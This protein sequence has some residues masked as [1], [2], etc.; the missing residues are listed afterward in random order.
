MRSAHTARY[1]AAARE[2]RGP[3]RRESGTSR[4]SISPSSSQSGERRATKDSLSNTLL[5][6]DRAQ[7]QE[8][9]KTRCVSIGYAE[10]CGVQRREHVGEL[11]LAQR[12]QFRRATQ[13]ELQRFEH[14]AR[15]IDAFGQGGELARLQRR[16]QAHGIA[17]ARSL[18]EDDHG[19]GGPI[20]QATEARI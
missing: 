12:L 10:P 17:Q 11:V 1:N 20:P 8:P 5:V 9:Q 19:V 15:Q 3:E 13:K 2:M 4:F 6:P 18:F 14:G 7:V 16:L